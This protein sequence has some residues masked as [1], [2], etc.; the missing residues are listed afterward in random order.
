MDIHEHWKTI[1]MVFNQATASTHF[2]SV[3]TVNRDG[4]PRI[5]PIGSLFLT[6][7][8]KAIYFESFPKDMR[9]NLEQ[10]PRICVLAVASGMWTTL[11]AMFTGRFDR[12]PGV[13]LIGRAGIRRKATEEET[14]MWQQ[15]VKAFR[16]FKGYHLLWNDMDHVREVTFD[17]F[18]PLRMG[19]MGRGLWGGVKE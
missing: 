9:Q 2:C 10:D 4:S 8:G 3:A 6:G 16:R 13:R 11:K 12:P 18:E 1:S 17:S 14:K 7:T 5:S 19:V 15:R